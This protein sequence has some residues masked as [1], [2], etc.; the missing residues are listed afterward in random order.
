MVEIF[1]DISADNE[2][3]TRFSLVTAGEL[4]EY[5]QVVTR[6]GGAGLDQLSGADRTRLIRLALRLI[7]ARH[8]LGRIDEAFM[9]TVLAARRRFAD[10]LPPEL[11]ATFAPYDRERYFADGTLLDNLLFGKVV[12]TSSLAVKKVNAIVEEVLDA[13]ALRGLVLEVGLDHHVGLFGGRLSPPQRQRVA[14]ARALLKRPDILIL[15]GALGALEPGERQELHQRVLTAMKDRTVIAVVERPDL[16]RLYDRVVVLDAGA[17]VETGTYQE[18][19]GQRSGVLHA[20]ATQA[21]VR[22]G[23]G[24]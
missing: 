16:A 24:E 15:D 11:A 18:L 21:G 2:L 5:A 3:F 10:T 6:V 4:P 19:I 20:I 22:I 7:P 9:T 17:V 12:A 8:R 1:K 13:R 23:K 14:L